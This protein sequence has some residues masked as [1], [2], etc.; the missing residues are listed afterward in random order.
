[1]EAGTLS[2]E[3]ISTAHDITGCGLRAAAPRQ[4]EGSIGIPVDDVLCAVIMER[5]ESIAVI[6]FERLGYLRASGRG[7]RQHRCPDRSRNRHVATIPSNAI[8]LRRGNGT[9]ICGPRP[10]KVLATKRRNMW[11]RAQTFADTISQSDNAQ[12]IELAQSQ[13]KEWV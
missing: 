4:R 9:S 8:G 11:F 5:D 12:W 2:L 1:M 3:G 6:G 7:Q 10:I 13:Q